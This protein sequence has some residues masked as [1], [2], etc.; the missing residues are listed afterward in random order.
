MTRPTDTDRSPEECT[1]CGGKGYHW[2]HGVRH[3]MRRCGT[4]SGNG[5]VRKGARPLA[6]AA[7][8][9]LI[10]AGPQGM[11]GSELAEALKIGRR[12]VSRLMYSRHQA[13]SPLRGVGFHKGREVEMYGTT[14]WSLVGI[15]R[16]GELPFVA[17]SA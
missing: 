2:K 10:K 8:A 3:P 12:D 7:L 5:T 13:E 9:L 15:R 17:P 6:Q 14:A 16:A 1:A 11:T 4:C